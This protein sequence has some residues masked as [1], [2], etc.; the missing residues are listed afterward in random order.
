ML[1]SATGLPELNNYG[2]DFIKAVAEPVG[3]VV[4]MVMEPVLPCRRWTS[5]AA[6][7]L[8]GTPTKFM[9]VGGA[10]TIE[11]ITRAFKI[12]MDDLA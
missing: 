7:S 11:A 10:S 2:C 5:P 12:I 6:S 9:D 3:S 4:C 1:T 8:G